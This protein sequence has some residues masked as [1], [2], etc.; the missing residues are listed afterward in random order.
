MSISNPGMSVPSRWVRGG[1]SWRLV[2]ALAVAG[3]GSDHPSAKSSDPSPP[4]STGTESTGGERPRLVGITFYTVSKIVAGLVGVASIAYGLYKA[5]HSD[6][7]PPPSAGD[8]FCIDNKTEAALMDDVD[9]RTGYIQKIQDWIS[10]ISNQGSN[11]MCWA[12]VNNDQPPQ[13]Y[14]VKLQVKNQQGSIAVLQACI[15]AELKLIPDGSPAA[16][17]VYNK[18][19]SGS[20]YDSS[21]MEWIQSV[22][23]TDYQGDTVM[24]N[25][26]EA[27]GG[28]CNG[29][30]SGA[31]VGA[32]GSGD[33]QTDAGSGCSSASDCVNSSGLECCVASQ[34]MSPTQAYLAG[35]ICARDCQTSVALLPPGDDYICCNVPEDCPPQSGFVCLAGFCVQAGAMMNPPAP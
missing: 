8:D 14:T 15:D 20:G 19:C 18:S 5:T 22:P 4:E 2:F 34:C 7:G 21:V 16:W 31:A 26:P 6:P 17:A 23:E 28:T 10:N 30:A 25:T 35:G 11:W 9:K 33:S 3:C 27:W 13:C 29:G 12:L 1:L 24:G 32:G